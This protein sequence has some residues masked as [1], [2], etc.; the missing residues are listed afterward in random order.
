MKYQASIMTK[1]IFVLAIAAPASPQDDPLAGDTDLPNY[2]RLS[3]QIAIAGQ[4]TDEG[5]KKIKKA[6]FK[7]VMQFRSLEKASAT[8]EQTVADLDM[9]YAYFPYNG[10][11]DAL[12]EGF[13]RAVSDPSNKP[14]FIHCG[15]VNIVTGL[16]YVYRVLNDH[17]PEEEAFAE[18]KELGLDQPKIEQAAKDYVREKRS[19]ASK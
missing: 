10:I 17:I 12:V 14:I 5:L 8:E 11:D 4:P 7:A 6:G 3:D 15:K 18:A 9:A 2:V 16:W 13:S 1:L 19:L